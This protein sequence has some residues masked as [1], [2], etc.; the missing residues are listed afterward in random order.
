[1]YLKMRRKK[2]IQISVLRD[3]CV[4]EEHVASIF[5]TEELAKQEKNKLRLSL[6]ASLKAEWLHDWMGI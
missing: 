1:M 6:P 2:F 3:P 5:R 4:S